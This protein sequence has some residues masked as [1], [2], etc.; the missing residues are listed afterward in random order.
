VAVPVDTA[1]FVVVAFAGT[2]TAGE[3]GELFTTNVAV[4]GMVTVLSIPWI[5][6]VRAGEPDQ[7]PASG[8]IRP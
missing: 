7:P 5:Y 6:L 8:E 3:V 1:I 4:K 2:V